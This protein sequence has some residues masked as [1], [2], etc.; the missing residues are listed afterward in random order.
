[1]STSVIFNLLGGLGLFLYGIKIMGEA[2]QDL[3][4]D[5]MR[6]LIAALTSTP[7]KGVL[8][9]TLVTMLIQSSSATTVMATSFVH[10]GLMTLKQA[11]GV[12]MGAAIGTTITAQIIA[13]KISAF[14][15][16][17]IGVGMV[18]AVFGKTKRQK[19]I[20]NGI[21]GFGLLFVGM[22]TMEHAMYFLR[23]HQGLFLA[24]SH[25]PL[26]G[27]IAGTALTM[28]VQS[29]SATV[30]LTMAMASQGL[31]P[32]EA[33]IPILFGDN[34]GTT[35]TAVLASLGLN[36]S[37]KQAAFAHVFF[38]V[39]GVVIFL[40]I[41]PFFLKIVAMSSHDISRQIANAH[42]MFNVMNTM[43]F[44]PFTGLFEKFVR[45]VV[46]DTGEVMQMGPRFLDRNL[47]TAS[48]VAAVEAVR[49]EM[50]R[51]GLLVKDM[52]QD[53]SR[54]FI[55]EDAKV[56]NQVLQAERCVNELTREITAYSTELMQE[57]L[58]PVQSKSLSFYVN[59]IGDLER[60][61]DHAENLIELFEY[62][63]ENKIVF[64]E[65]AIKEFKD[66][67]KIVLDAVTLSVETL[68]NVDLS[69]VEKVLWLEVEIDKMERHLRK[70]HIERLN[71]GVCQPS[72]AVVFI[73]ILSNLERVG[74]HAHNVALLVKDIEQARN[75]E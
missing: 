53:V 10:A 4:G 74:D 13:F 8:V 47:I 58:P 2:L 75:E 30:G 44:L 36:R 9:G 1:L 5:R 33:A 71:E 11:I 27:V 57:A 50:V 17:L 31:L 32:L 35:I 49:K 65:Q 21:V 41:L 55:E 68:E 73:D 7:F 72:A 56:I 70:R 37:A 26:L 52:L 59:G 28:V 62:K 3:A 48:P 38:K 34:I 69:K 23:D 67:M 16:P 42:T 63:I 60:I 12:I 39:I 14:A 66:M 61:G 29:S 40:S 15:M 22:K 43:I 19:Y 64:S 6:K 24:F 54:A 45:K 18:F 51:L 46:P 20:G 25:N